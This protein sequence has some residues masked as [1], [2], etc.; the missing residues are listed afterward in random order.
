MTVVAD[1]NVRISENLHRIEDTCNVYLLK[2][3]RDG[4]LIDFGDGSVL[5]HLDEHGVDRITDV[6][7]THH[8]RDQAQGLS[9]AARSVPAGRPV[10]KS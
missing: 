2:S 3:G 7:L 1:A 6:L 4:V 10:V 9:R 8:H 5:D